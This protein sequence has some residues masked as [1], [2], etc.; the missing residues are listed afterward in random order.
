MQEPKPISFPADA[1]A[2]VARG[3]LRLAAAARRGAGDAD[4]ARGSM[5]GENLDYSDQDFYDVKDLK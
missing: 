5:G 2:D 4:L 1:Q 3:G